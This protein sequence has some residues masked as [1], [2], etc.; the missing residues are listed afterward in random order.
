VIVSEPSIAAAGIVAIARALGDAM[1]PAAAVQTFDALSQSAPVDV[2][3]SA[4]TASSRALAV[5]LVASYRNLR[6]AALAAYCEAIVRTELSDRRAALTL[7]ANVAEYFEAEMDRLTADQ[8]DL[9][10]AMAALRN[11][12][13]DFLSRA[14]LDLAPVISVTANMSMPSVFWAWRLYSDP[15]RS[16]DLVARNRV[17]HPSFMATEFEAL[18]R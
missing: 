7:R 18:A 11:A 8:S 2:D 17:V 1:P 13:V 9:Y 3:M 6:L 10:N 12:T 14:V 4:R 16:A 5:N 15:A